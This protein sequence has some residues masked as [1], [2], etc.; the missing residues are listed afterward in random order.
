MIFTIKTS[1]EVSGLDIARALDK[2]GIN[3]TILSKT[4]E[5]KTCPACHGE[6]VIQTRWVGLVVCTNCNGKGKA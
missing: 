6:G 4:R 2:A 1:D 5:D 3:H